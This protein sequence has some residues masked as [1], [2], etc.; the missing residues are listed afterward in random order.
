MTSRRT[1][2]PASR[3]E[4][5]AAIIASGRNMLIVM[6][7]APDPDALAAAGALRFIAN[8]LSDVAC[9]LTHGG[10]ISR[11]ENQAMARYLGYTLRPFQDITPERFDLIAM[12]DTQP[13]TGNNVLPIHIVPQIVI[14]H[15]P[16]HR[17][18]RS[19][20]YT[21]IRRRYGATSTIL[22]EYLSGFGL[23]P[24]M[25]LA[26]A[27][28]YG[29]R[30]DTQDL[31]RDATQADTDAF[32]ALYPMVNTRMLARIQRAPLPTDY[33]WVLNHALQ[34]AV[35]AGNAVFSFLGNVANPDSIA[36]VADLLLR[37]E[38]AQWALC[39]GISGERLLLS[40]RSSPE[41]DHF[42]CGRVA[43]TVVHRM[44]TGGGHQTMAGGQITL[45]S[46]SSVRISTVVTA[47]RKRFFR[48][49]HVPD[50]PVRLLK[51][52]RSNAS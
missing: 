18:T 29:I 26:T 4:K 7:D 45:T 47:V 13:G 51:R 50:T 35:M 31:G 2:T 39:C 32:L 20:P 25:P 1:R 46:R 5:L 14:D 10:R 9:S 43:R 33:Y 22:F 15:H 52:G 42:D 21:D 49:V 36:E 23:T 44:G 8:S 19:S 38:A 16:V 48:A 3:L 11:A 24:D 41:L 34:N 6:Q 17:A 28:L 27:L 37:H 12:V 40:I 30:S